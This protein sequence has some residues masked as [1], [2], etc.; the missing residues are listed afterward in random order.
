MVYI[1]RHETSSIKDLH[2]IFLK[3]HILY[4]ILITHKQYIYIYITWYLYYSLTPYI[5]MFVISKHNV[6]NST[7]VINKR[8]VAYDI[9]IKI[10]LGVK[11][12]A[13][14]LSNIFWS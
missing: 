8:Y 13:N 4:S 11:F 5:S 6:S 10:L 12:H 14:R 7:L 9:I 2:V 3:Q 1:T